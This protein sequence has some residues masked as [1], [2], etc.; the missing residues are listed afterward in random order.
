V[1]S[2]KKP[3]SV[4]QQRFETYAEDISYVCGDP[5]FNDDENSLAGIF[6]GR[7]A[8]VCFMPQEKVMYGS[9]KFP[10]FCSI[11]GIDNQSL[12][13]NMESERVKALCGGK[14][15]YPMCERCLE[16][17]FSPV[18][19]GAADHTGAAYKRRKGGARKNKAESDDEELTRSSSDED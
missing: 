10:D 8:L 12:L 17:G 18:T 16:E 5:V 4:E 2:D 3:K 6:Y 14:R 15:A 9:K 7:R 13:V 11:C 1:F 19:H